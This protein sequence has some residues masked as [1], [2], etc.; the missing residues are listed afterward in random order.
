M[1][2]EDWFP[3]WNNMEIVD[4]IL[5]TFIVGEGDE[6]IGHSCLVCLEEFEVGTSYAHM[7]QCLHL[8]HVNCIVN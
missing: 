7:P 2:I 4:L 5:I 8:F 3:Y 6:Q 1:A